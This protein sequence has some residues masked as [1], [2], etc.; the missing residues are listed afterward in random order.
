[1]YV[2]IIWKDPV[3]HHQNGIYLHATLGI[4]WEDLLTAM[5]IDPGNKALP[6][7]LVYHMAILMLL[8]TLV[9]PLSFKQDW[10]S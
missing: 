10:M 9:H 8:V 3:P 5:I 1:M 2:D 6:S 7:L 4:N